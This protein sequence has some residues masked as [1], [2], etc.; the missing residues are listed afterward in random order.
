MSAALAHD[1]VDGFVLLYHYR[2]DPKPGSV[3]LASHTGCCV[4]TIAKDVKTATGEYF[5]GRGRMTFGTMDW[6]RRI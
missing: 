5:N 6:T 2:N 1:S 4:M 3:G